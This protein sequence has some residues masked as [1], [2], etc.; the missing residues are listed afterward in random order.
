MDCQAKLNTFKQLDRKEQLANWQMLVNIAKSFLQNGTN[1]AVLA[2]EISRIIYGHRMLMA[3]S[4]AYENA[5]DM[6][7]NLC[8]LA[9][10]IARVAYFN[11]RK[12]NLL[13]TNSSKVFCI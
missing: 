2:G 11:K 5:V 12:L 4:K 7:I 1:N 8:K 3:S 13:Y 9:L 10:E 6:D